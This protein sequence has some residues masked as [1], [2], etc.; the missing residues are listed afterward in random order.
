MDERSARLAQNEAV[1]RAGN[2]RIDAIIPTTS[3]T[4]PYLCECGN[5]ECFEPVPLTHVEYEGVRAHP[6]RFFVASGHEDL[7]AGEVVVEDLGRYTIVEKQGGAGEIA[8]RT[9]PRSA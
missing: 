7:S 2:E 5:A 4:A 6:A 9:D 1:F 3:G 8:A